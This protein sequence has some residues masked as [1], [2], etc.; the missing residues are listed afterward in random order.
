[1]NSDQVLFIMCAGIELSKFLI[2]A[3]IVGYITFKLS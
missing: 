1:M 3:A 2:P